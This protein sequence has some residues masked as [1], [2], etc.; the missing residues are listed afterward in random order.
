MS[1]LGIKN[2]KEPSAFGCGSQK[3]H[4]EAQVKEEFAHVGA[5]ELGISE[6]RVPRS[7]RQR[8]SASSP[9]PGKPFT[10]PGGGRLQEHTGPV[11]ALRDR[12]QK[13]GSG[14]GYSTEAP[15]FFLMSWRPYP[16]AL[17]SWAGS[18]GFKAKRLSLSER[19]VQQ[20]AEFQLSFPFS[21]RKQTVG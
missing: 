12:G 7:R 6:E 14:V 20:G 17:V 10:E 8:E 21:G 3:T 11:S 18:R 2:E 13:C 15:P 9:G 16:L 5:G 1:I 4:Q 19:Q